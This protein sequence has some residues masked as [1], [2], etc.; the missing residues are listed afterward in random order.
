MLFFL[1]LLSALL[2]WT[3]RDG[4]S[5]YEDFVVKQR[6]LDNGALQLYAPYVLWNNHVEPT[7]PPLQYPLVLVSVNGLLDITL[8]V[9]AVRISTAPFDYTTRVFCYQDICNSPGPTLYLNPGDRL[10]IRLINELEPSNNGANRTN[11]F[12]QNLPVDVAQNSPQVFADG[13]E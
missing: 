1:Q 9:R 4:V 7:S 5:A 3:Q 6:T 13:G 11:V 12:I 10:K 8:H 2:L